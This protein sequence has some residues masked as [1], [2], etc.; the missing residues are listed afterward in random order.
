[1][2][3]E[4]RIRKQYHDG[5]LDVNLT[6]DGGIFALLGEKDGAMSRALRCI[7]GIETPD[8]G[9]IVL[10]NV[11]LYDSLAH[12]NLP[13][14]KRRVG[15]LFPGGALFPTAS[16]EENIRMAL[17]G[18]G[19]ELLESSTDCKTSPAILSTRVNEFLQEYHLDGLGGSYPDELTP[20][21]R[22]QA[23]FARMMAGNPRLVLLDEPFAA[24][25][26]YRK[27]EVLRQM[28][29]AL[30]E[31][32]LQAVLAST[33][34]DEVYAM[35]DHVSSLHRG[36][37]EPMQAVH[38]FFDHPRTLQAALLSGCRNIGTAH[39]V[40]PFHALVPAWG[41]LFSFR[42]EQGSLVHLPESLGAIGIRE[43][44]FLQEPPL[45][46]QGHRIPCYRFSVY[47][48]RVIARRNEVDLW[49]EPGRREGGGT[50]VY[51]I[52]KSVWE[53]TGTAVIERLYV[54]MDHI[55][56]LVP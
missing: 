5:M 36:R 54:R 45:D 19:R 25:D 38:E 26:S 27:A 55:L 47:R 33:D 30:Q 2:S 56:R 37:V 35:G 51:T 24:F 4:V 18:G 40:D 17:M 15:Y 13:S 39:L 50:L 8:E 21:Q 28:Q 43:R 52:P 41:A 20:L 23:A 31:H 46:E 7:A 1:M 6:S 3:L 44:D 29:Q 22:C 42:D 32:H 9:R 11:V 49:F 48:P 14:D 53:N 34:M 16:V 10:D 12:V